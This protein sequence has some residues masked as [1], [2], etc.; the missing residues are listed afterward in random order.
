MK[1]SVEKS[2]LLH[3]LQHVNKAIPTRS[4]LPI[5]SC[6]LFE[7]IEEHLSIRATNLEVYISVKI[8]V[9]DAVVGRV[10]IPLNTL[11]DITSAMPEEYLHFE[12]SD[13][14]KVNIK[15]TCGKYTI[16]GLPA[17]EFPAEPAVEVGNSLVVPAT[18]LNNIIES[19]IYA[20]S[21]DE[22]KPVLQGVL[23]NMASE[24]LTAVA[25]DGHRLVR[26][27][28]IELKAGSF[29]G[30]V[31]IPVKFLSLLKPFLKK[32]ESLSLQIGENHIMINLGHVKVSS[33]I[34]KDRYPDYES[35]IPKDN[36]CELT[37]NKN[38]LAGS[39]K[40]VSIF[41]NKS[42]KQI[43]LSLAANKIT[44]STEDPENIT[45]GKESID[46]L[47]SGDPMVV[48]YNSQYLGDVLKN[49]NSEEIKILF[50]SPLSAGIFLPK[51]QL[52][53]E[54]KTTLLMP[55]RLND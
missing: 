54:E 21:K 35:V 2:T 53:G 12:I 40:R 46:C 38:D 19:T 20:T 18:E 41:S 3:S 15:S 16:M 33:R 17:D 47:Y 22:L 49:Q 50:K 52:D 30:S 25:T 5:L 6:A 42:T 13:I 44:I 55:I 31:I 29:E 8:E 48:G 1:F 7:I 24:G 39:V 43:A 11:L 28:K 36:E 26:L 45:T 51:E 32:D 14:G 27:K 10:A 4:T 9:E 23:I 37:I 34:I